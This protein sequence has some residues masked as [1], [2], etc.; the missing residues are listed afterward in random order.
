MQV[1]HLTHK[2]TLLTLP[3]TRDQA[4]VSLWETFSFKP[5]WGEGGKKGTKGGGKR[6]GK[7]GEKEGRLEGKDEGRKGG[8]DN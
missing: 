1:T 7:G 2:A 3:P 4:H 5:S 6:G 8:R